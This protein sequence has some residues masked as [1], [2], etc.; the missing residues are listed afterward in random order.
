MTI[1]RVPQA[2]GDS[3]IA[4]VRTTSVSCLRNFVATASVV[5]SVVTAF[6][7]AVSAKSP[8]KAKARKNAPAHVRVETA[9]LRSGPGQ[10]HRTVALLDAGRQARVVTRSGDWMRVRLQSGTLGWVRADLLKVSQAAPSSPVSRK[11]TVRNKKSVS[12]R[13]AAAPARAASKKARPVT[14]AASVKKAPPVSSPARMASLRRQRFVRAVALRPTTVTP[15]RTSG[16]EK[17]APVMA[18]PSGETS[19]AKETTAVVETSA[20]AAP[21]KVARASAV[22]KPLPPSRGERLVRTALSFRG[23]PYRRGASGR[24]AFDCSGFTSYLFRKAG[25]PLPR[26]AAAQYTRGGRV[27]K[28]EL[29]PGDLVFF[30]NTYKRGVSH[31]GVYIGNG[32]FVHAASSGRGVRVDSLSSAYYQNHWAGARRPR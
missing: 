32:R 30:K 7:P 16:E 18:I 27:S 4:D 1:L 8:T 9:L 10:T 20:V 24:G 13:V 31:V 6:S 3:R 23:T 28:N 11:T 22:A 12:R 15:L 17:T 21:V 19:E 2:A 14:T 5:V 25:S 26:T 29:R